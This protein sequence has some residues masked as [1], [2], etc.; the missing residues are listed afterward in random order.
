M[1]RTTIW[2]NKK[3]CSQNGYPK[4]DTASSICTPSCPILEPP[5]HQRPCCLV[6][7][8][9]SV[10]WEA[11]LQNQRATKAMAEWE[12]ISTLQIWFTAS[13]L[14]LDPCQ[15]AW[16]VEEQTYFWP[17]LTKTWR[18]DVKE[19]RLS[20]LGGF[21]SW[22]QFTASHVTLL[23]FKCVQV[24]GCVKVLGGKVEVCYHL[25]SVSGSSFLTQYSTNWCLFSLGL[26]KNICLCINI[27]EHARYLMTL[28]LHTAPQIFMIS[29]YPTADS[30]LSWAVL[31]LIINFT[32]RSSKVNI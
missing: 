12:P 32:L 3:K 5:P 20:E 31:C 30:D 15:P 4:T 6:C 14:Y 18:R 21:S 22:N 16:R 24:E 11:Q 1:Y 7:M 19:K 13:G 10:R 8:K 9:F 25:K 29:K 17:Q 28:Y 27:L 23:N 2:E 26:R